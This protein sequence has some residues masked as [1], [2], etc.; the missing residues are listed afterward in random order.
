VVQQKFTVGSIVYVNK[1]DPP[2]SP[3]PPEAGEKEM[4]KWDKD[5]LWVAKVLEVR[6]TDTSHVYLRVFWLYWP[7]ELPNGRQKYHGANELVMSNAMEIVDAMS[8]AAEAEVK[9]WDESNDEQEDL[10]PVFF[11]QF[12]DIN[13]K[14]GPMLSELRR[15]C[16]CNEYYQPD[17]TMYKCSKRD[18]ETWNH[19]ECLVDDVLEKPYA[20]HVARQGPNGDKAT[21]SASRSKTKSD[22][23][24]SKA[25]KGEAGTKRPWTGM[26]SAVIRNNEGAV[27]GLH[28]LISETSEPSASWTE[29]VPCLKCGEALD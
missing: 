29:S 4:L 3:P 24:A 22:T 15:H 19:E 25:P 6:A 27:G 21:S 23:A 9:Q 7:D 10:G 16:V 20:K 14:G 8:V 11:R 12:L 5:N 26:F 17:K 28:V 2:A 18:C 1:S 13:A